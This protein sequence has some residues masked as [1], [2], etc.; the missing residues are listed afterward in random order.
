MRRYAYKP[1]T[2]TVPLVVFSSR[3]AT[4]VLAW[5]EA[6][7]AAFAL[8]TARADVATLAEHYA[9]ACASMG[10]ANRTKMDMRRIWQ[11][12]AF[13]RINGVRKQ[14]RAAAAALADAMADPALASDQVAA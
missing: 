7:K 11:A 3:P 5:S 4:D 13:R 12:K 9:V 8:E 1:S 14:M 2:I 10:K 6:Q